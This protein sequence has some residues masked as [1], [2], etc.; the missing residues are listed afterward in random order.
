MLIGDVPESRQLV[1][2]AGPGPLRSD[3]GIHEEGRGK[4]DDQPHRRAAPDRKNEP[5]RLTGHLAAPDRKSGDRAAG[6]TAGYEALG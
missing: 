4:S 6:I 3:D 2:V 5:A 1:N